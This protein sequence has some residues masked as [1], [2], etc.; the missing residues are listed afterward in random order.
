MPK[1]PQSPTGPTPATD[2]N[3]RVFTA[4]INFLEVEP[5][6]LISIVVDREDGCLFDSLELYEA[7]SAENPHY[8]T[9]QSWENSRTWLESALALEGF[10]NLDDVGSYSIVTAP[11]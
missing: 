7:E 3:G 5:Y 6:P 1:T 10:V 4:E 2:V 11:S 9:L 8:F